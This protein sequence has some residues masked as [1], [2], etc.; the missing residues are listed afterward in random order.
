MPLF[1]LDISATVLKLLAKAPESHPEIILEAPQALIKTAQ[2]RDLHELS[3]ILTLSFH[4]P[5]GLMKWLIPILR[6]GIY[7]DLRQRLTNQAAHY[8]CLVATQPQQHCRENTGS[9]SVEF[10]SEMSPSNMSPSNVVGE[11]TFG[12]PVGTV[13]VSVRQRNLWQSGSKYVYLS[14]LAVREDCRRQGVG[15]QLL[16]GCEQVARQWGFRDIYLH[17]LDSNAQANCLYQKLNYQVEQVE[18]DLFAMLLNR[19]R[20]VLLHKKIDR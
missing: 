2:L 20:Q 11:R 19:P 17:V 5:E 7:E 13:E 16:L 14:N 15:N 1:R 8:T 18:A 10:R 4:R 9:D 3:D 6:L 12:E